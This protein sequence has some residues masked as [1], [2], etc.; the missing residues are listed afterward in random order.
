MVDED[1]IA[2][3]KSKDFFYISPST[4]NTIAACSMQYYFGKVLKLPTKEALPLTYGNL[5]HDLL[6]SICGQIKNKEKISIEKAWESDAE[7]GYKTGVYKPLHAIWDS[8]EGADWSDI[9]PTKQVL[10]VEKERLTKSCETFIKG[11]ALEIQPVFMEPLMVS[12]VPGSNRKLHLLG[13]I[14][15]GAIYKD[16]FWVIDHKSAKTMPKI[17]KASGLYMVKPEYK[18]QLTAYCAA[19]WDWKLPKGGQKCMLAYMSKAKAPEQI[20]V[21]VVITQ[22]D[23]DALAK[24]LVCYEEIIHQN[25]FTINRG[26]TLCS[27]KFCSFWEACHERFG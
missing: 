25:L 8:Y 13:Y 21:E 22:K 27:E 17:H 14:D 6:E 9:E 7:A 12:P 1:L 19:L 24:K 5:L 3:S 11:L 2:K 18:Q 10:A 15:L 4:A 16:E 20:R 26:Y 23:V